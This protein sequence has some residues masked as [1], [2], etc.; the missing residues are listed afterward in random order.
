M[1]AFQTG[2]EIG[3]FFRH[4]NEAQHGLKGFGYLKWN[5]T[6]VEGELNTDVSVSMKEEN[7][8]YL[9]NFNK[10]IENY[11]HPVHPNA[12]VQLED[13]LRSRHLDEKGIVFTNQDIS[14]ENIL[15]QTSGRI[16]LIDPV[17]ILYSGDSFAGNF[18]N[19]YNTLFPLCYNSPRY[20]KHQFEQYEEHLQ[21]IANGF[22]EGYCG[23]DPDARL[24]VKQEEFIKMTDFA[25]SMHDLSQQDELTIEQRIRFGEKEAIANRVHSLVK[26]IEQFQWDVE[27]SGSKLA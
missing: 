25:A 6:A 21:T 5:G 2:A 26:R 16:S 18:M 12:A 11:E 20:A 27:K 8:F 22:F 24:R 3:E 7:E 23:S 15:I 1:E 17:P 4:M 9:S 10:F 19:L 14:P 13:C